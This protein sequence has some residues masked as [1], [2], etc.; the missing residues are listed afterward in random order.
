MALET[1]V[2]EAN[3]RVQGGGSNPDGFSSTFQRK[4]PDTGE[5]TTKQLTVTFLEVYQ[6]WKYYAL[7]ESA[8]TDYITAHPE[9]ALQ[10][11]RQSEFSDAFT[12]SKRTSTRTGTSYTLADVPETT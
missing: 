6:E 12:L 2:N 3:W 4:D 1:S 11:A 7:T 9:L 8:C 5:Y 10:Y